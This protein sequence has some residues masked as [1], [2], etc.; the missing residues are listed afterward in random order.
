MRGID[1]FEEELNA[2]T[3]QIVEQLWDAARDLLTEQL[4]FGD[5]AYTIFLVYT[6]IY[7]SRYEVFLAWG[8]WAPACRQ[9]CSSHFANLTTWRIVQTVFPFYTLILCIFIWCKLYSQASAAAPHTYVSNPTMQRFAR[10]GKVLRYSQQCASLEN[11]RTALHE[12]T[13]FACHT[14]I[15][16]LSRRRSTSTLR[17]QQIQKRGEYQLV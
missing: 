8:M 2:V 5:L 12:V 15:L 17:E 6:C 14:L 16:G 7:F 11:L 4:V 9:P 3:P 13:N 1:A 10:R